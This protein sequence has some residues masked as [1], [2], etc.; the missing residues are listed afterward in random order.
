MT[1]RFRWIPF[2]AAVI[3][4]A[5]G[6]SLGNW[7]ERRA[8]QKEE[9]Q[10]QITERAAMPALQAAAL[11][12]GARPDEFRQIVADG[13]FVADWPMYLENRPLDGHA[14]FYLLM[15][16]R[17][18]GSD[19]I[20]LV[21]RGWFARDARDRAHIPEIPT[22]A[23]RLQL[24]G[25]VRADTGQVMQLG[26]RVAPAP[27]AILQNFDLR[28]YASASKLPV[29]AFIIEQTSDTQDGLRRDWPQPTFGID[30]HH[31]Y[32]FQWYSLAA[33]ALLFFFMTG[34]KRASK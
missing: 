30:T 13:A 24:R 34:F 1:F 22:P 33:A 14:G 31:G 21:E 27:G 16:F 5:I 28:A 32:A 17:L 18:A 19:A 10:R 6:I 26:E 11:A 7:Q 9:L 3:V 20:V 25:R 2:I 15:P 4:A 8:A 12:P 23:G 29:H